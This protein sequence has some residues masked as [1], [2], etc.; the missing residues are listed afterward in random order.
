M[1][2]ANEEEVSLAPSIEQRDNSLGLPKLPS[3]YGKLYK[4]P[5]VDADWYQA[6][7]PDSAA[8]AEQL[9]LTAA[10]FSSMLFIN[11]YL[12]FIRV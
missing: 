6:E 8:F 1:D 10:S 9:P 11:F 4:A 5:K 7:L 2:G 3:S 12:L